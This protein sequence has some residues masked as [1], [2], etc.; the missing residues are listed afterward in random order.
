MAEEQT[1]TTAGSCRARCG[2]R[3]VRGDTGLGRTAAAAPAL[4][5]VFERHLPRVLRALMALESATPQ[6]PAVAAHYYL[7]FLGVDPS[8][9]GRGLGSGG[10]CA[11]DRPLRRRAVPA[12][13]EAST[14]RN[15]ALYERHGF[16]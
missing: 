6:A 4:G 11:G 9:Q 12:Y 16:R 1:F 13:L 3:P 2:S 15:R 7:A 8:W 14:P 10:A 5:G